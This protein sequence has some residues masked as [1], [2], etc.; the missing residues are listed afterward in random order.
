M[1]VGDKVIF[2]FAG[3]QKE[4]IIV[5]VSPKKVYIKADFPRHKGKIIKRSIFEVKTK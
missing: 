4:G 5:K 1:K 3:G 2:P